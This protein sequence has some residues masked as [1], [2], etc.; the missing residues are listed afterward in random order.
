MRRLTWVEGHTADFGHRTG[1]TLRDVPRF[2]YRLRLFVGSEERDLERRDNRTWRPAQRLYVLRFF[3]M[4]TILSL[5]E[6]RGVS[7]AL[8]LRVEIQMKSGHLPWAKK[9][10]TGQSIDLQE[11][12]DYYWGSKTHEVT[13]SGQTLLPSSPLIPDRGV[14]RSLWLENIVTVWNYNSLRKLLFVSLRLLIVASRH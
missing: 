9:E 4:W 6:C 3:P 7:L 10:Q 2:K 11:V 1:I 13:V 8:Q 5:C 14:Q 12:F